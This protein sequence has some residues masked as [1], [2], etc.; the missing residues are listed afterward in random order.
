[1]DKDGLDKLVSQALMIEQD[2]AKE[3]G[4]LGYAARILV[5]ATIPHSK[6]EELFFQRSNG[7]F[8]LVMVGHPDFGLPYGAIARLIL[9]YVSTEAVR[10]KL[11][12]VRLGSSMSEFMH[13]LELQP[14][15]GQTGS[16]TYLKE[17]I[18]RLFTTSIS[19]SFEEDAGKG[20]HWVEEGFRIAERTFLWWDTENPKGEEIKV[21]SCVQLSDKFFNEVIQH[22]IP[23]DLRALKALRR[24]PL[25]L[26]IY[27]WLT[28]RFYNLKKPIVIPWPAL[29]VQFG[30]DYSDPR[31]FRRKFL[32]QLK[33][34][35]VV[36]PQANVKPVPKL[37]LGLWPSPTHITPVH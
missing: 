30:S 31:N 34:V 1:M 26:D 11:P 12:V 21:P 29:M 18:Q 22:P 24:S 6:P 15:G 10:T 4:T 9:A 8:K 25:A 5:L 17:H 28:Y 7:N 14:T 13:K 32:M 16:I 23:L 37:G 33:K 20:A 36:Y 19:C 27:T 35:K 2:E 3:A